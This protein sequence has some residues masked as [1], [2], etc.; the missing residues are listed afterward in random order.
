M[1]VKV[2][3]PVV[4]RRVELAVW[5]WGGGAAGALSALLRVCVLRVVVQKDGSAVLRSEVFQSADRQLA[6]K[7]Q[8][9]SKRTN[10]NTSPAP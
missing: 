6:Q 1:C 7:G 8:S 2:C 5:V 9:L 3:V 10:A 4:C